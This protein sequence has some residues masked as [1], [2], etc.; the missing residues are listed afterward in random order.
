MFIKNKKIKNSKNIN[1]SKCVALKNDV[2]ALSIMKIIMTSN[3]IGC[4][5]L[6]V[7]F[8]IKV[9]SELFNVICSFCVIFIYLL[10]IFNFNFYLIV[11]SW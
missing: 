8:I 9:K 11:L 3:E 7:I 2:F 10:Y 5:I 1:K 6:L 4:Y